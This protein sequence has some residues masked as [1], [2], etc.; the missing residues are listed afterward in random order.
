METCYNKYHCAR[1]EGLVDIKDRDKFVVGI[2]K[3]PLMKFSIDKLEIW[4]T[5]VRKQ[6]RIIVCSQKYLVS[7]RTKSVL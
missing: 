7:F 6:L 2:S 1:A 3:V 4:T 5:M